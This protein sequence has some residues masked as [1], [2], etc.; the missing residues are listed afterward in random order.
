MA[1]TLALYTCGPQLEIALDGH[2]LRATSLVRLAGTSARST[3]VLAA[4]DLL[5]EDAGIASDAIDR[6]LVTRGPGS[7]TGIRAGLA[8]ALGMAAWRPVEVAAFGSLDTLAARVVGPAK[9]W[10]AQPGRRGEVYARPFAVAPG[11]PPQATDELQVLRIG[12]LH[13]RGSWVAAE[14]LDLGAATR[15]E[16]SCSCAEALLRLVRLGA[17]SEPCEPLYVEAP[18]VH[19]KE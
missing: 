15:A 1:V 6:V 13:G 19:V 4:V 5:M 7:F 12:D 2:P 14:A 8:T 17:P 18:P 3:L 9:V 11:R 10:A 16:S